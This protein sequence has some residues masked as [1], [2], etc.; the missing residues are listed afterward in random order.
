MAGNFLTNDLSKLFVTTEFGSSATFTPQPSGTALS[1]VGIFDNEQQVFDAESNNY[2][3]AA[4]Q[5]QGKASLIG[6]AKLND[7]I[8]VNSST[9]YVMKALTNE[10]IT[11]LFLSQGRV[12]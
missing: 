9:F 3:T 10:G 12:S 1:F 7:K 11:T 5:I 4:S 6:S 2:I 8:E